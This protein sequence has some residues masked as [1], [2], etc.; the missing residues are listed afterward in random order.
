[1]TSAMR[2][3]PSYRAVASASSASTRAWILSGAI[4]VFLTVKNV[5]GIRRLAI[6]PWAAALHTQITYSRVSHTPRRPRRGSVK[7]ANGTPNSKHDNG[8]EKP[9]AARCPACGG[10]LRFSHR[11][12]VGRG[13]QAVVR[14]CANCG[15]SV[16]E[17]PRARVANAERGTRRQRPPIDEGAPANP[18]LDAE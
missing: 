3:R 10:E 9:R 5:R 11:D 6:S 1:M 14:R 15:S 13:L 7:N 17:A 18:V 12:Y 2:R 4:S 16:R 8:V